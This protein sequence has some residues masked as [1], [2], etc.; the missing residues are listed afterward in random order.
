MSLE[1]S[2]DRR[3]TRSAS[4]ARRAAETLNA[5]IERMDAL[6]RSQKSMMESLQEDM[7]EM[8]KELMRQ[9]TEAMQKMGASIQESMNQ[10]DK[11][12]VYPKK[13]SSRV[14]VNQT[15][16]K[17]E[18]KLS[19]Q[20]ELLSPGM[21]ESGIPITIFFD[22]GSMIDILSSKVVD[23]Y[24]LPTVPLKRPIEVRG[25]Q[26][27]GK[28]DR[29]REK[30]V[31]LTLRIGDHEEI[32]EF[33]V[34]KLDND[35]LLGLPWMQ[36]HGAKF[37][38]ESKKMYFA[39][40]CKDHMVT[41]NMQTIEIK[42]AGSVELSLTSEEIQDAGETL[43][44]TPLVR[45]SSI[46]A[47]HKWDEVGIGAKQFK[48]ILEDGENEI[49]AAVRVVK[50]T[51][52]EELEWPAVVQEFAEVFEK[53]AIPTLPEHR[54]Y[55]INIEL[56][57]DAKPTWGAIYN[58]STDEL[59]ALKNYI[60]DNVAAGFIRPSKS[61]YGAPVLVVKKKDGT[62]RFCIDYR[63]L[64]KQ[65]VKD[66][67][68]L[69]LISE[70]L[71]RVR[72]CKVFSKID[73][74][75]AYNL[76]RIKKGHEW[77]TAFRT[78]Y[79]H[80][81]YCVMPF[82]LS[83]APAA[84]QRMMNSIFHDM[85]DDFMI[86]YLDD[87]LIYSE[88]EEQHEEHLRKVMERLRDNKLM[89]KGEKCEFFRDKV[90]F[91][92]YVISNKGVR[93]DDGKVQTI[94]EWQAPT[95]VKELQ[96]F[97][98]FANF[99]R[100]FIDNYSKRTKNM[101]SLLKKGKP[102]I[103]AEAQQQEFEDLK[104]AF[105]TAP[106]L[107]SADFTKQFI[108]ETDASNFAI[109]AILS[110]RGEDNTEHPVA[111]YS[112]T[113]AAAEQNYQVH[114]KELLAIIEALKHWR[115]YLIGSP[116]PV[117]I[118]TDHRNLEHFMTSQ[119]L[120]QRQ[121]RW[122]Q[123]LADYNFNL[124]Y[125]PGAQQAKADALS[126]REELK[127][128]VPPNTA[129]EWLR[130][131]LDP[132]RIMIASVSTVEF[133]WL[134][135][136][137]RET[138]TEEYAQN[139]I[140]E[141]QNSGSRK[142][143]IQDGTLKKGE[144]TY[145]PENL[146]LR[147]TQ[148][149]HDALESGHKGVAKTLELLKRDFFWPKMEDYVARFVESCDL[150]QRTNANRHASYGEVQITE[151]PTR[152]WQIIG[153]DHAGPLPDSKGKN[154]V[155]II[156]D[157]LT[158]MVHF[159]ATEN[160]T[161]ATTTAELFRDHVWK[162]HGLPE[163]IISDRGPIFIS[164][165]WKRFFE[166]QGVRTAFATGYHPQTNGQ[167]ER[168]VQ[169]CKSYLRKF[170]NYHQDNWVD[171]LSTGEFAYNNTFHSTINDSPFHA[172]TGYHPRSHYSIPNRSEDPAAEDR[173]RELHKAQEKMSEIIVEGKEKT[174]QRVD[175]GRL[176]GP[177]FQVGEK[178]WLLGTNVVKSRRS[179]PLDH[180]KLGPFEITEKLGPVTYRLNLPVNMRRTHNTFHVSLL[181]KYYENPFPERV[182][183]PPPPI[184]IDGE[185]EFEV[186]EILDSRYRYHK[187]QYFVSWKGYTAEHNQWV[188]PEMLSCDELLPAY[189][190]NYPNNPGPAPTDRGQ[191]Q[192]VQGR[193]RRGR[194]R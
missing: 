137:R 103:W 148:E 77:M 35:L 95:K 67:Y 83:N 130:P 184:E 109:G 115:H 183:P 179:A 131:L 24:S 72:C 120:N 6:E 90:E 144:A 145:L 160:T 4:A 12:E 62:L 143:T 165:F 122:A 168:T 112:R 97:L 174:K 49:V 129:E 50:T 18:K 2:P 41:P 152:P 21:L 101:N 70:L 40:N 142:Y 105:A 177:D 117:Q 187:L 98:G 27:E 37:D 113:L 119:L 189:H 44:E 89:A 80:F 133:T 66:R 176:P 186:D 151:T 116:L 20:I 166:L 9:M 169:E 146:R 43:A 172:H 123:L 134:D 194:G 69:P 64:N 164:T 141:T 155:L 162:H 126:R 139:K 86:V 91:L 150:C 75:G 33:L 74:R 108:L 100:R 104:N 124:T 84:F 51:K 170:C 106:I 157:Y 47:H 26:P 175:K 158:K 31:P 93:M 42:S 171:L 94:K 125:R 15:S 118:L 8:G 128:E 32:R 56:V 25:F 107:A 85:L 65:T 3:N 1:R 173:I 10:R 111:F 30:T 11:T 102:Y 48:K 36:E 153:L 71:D 60:D 185:E 28:P 53:K 188:T 87:I 99:Y 22:G 81:E 59:K 68:P 46:K 136:I 76:M 167:A 178:V 135:E 159:I 181:E 78:R 114:D 147:A 156:T 82:G 161:D 14:R 7:Q 192:T 73:L 19:E 140:R 58:M 127:P 23:E 52:T 5:N 13:S 34:T 38:M 92:G 54:P 193:R 138:A 55:D 154:S 17:K 63:Q 96:R 88:N 16:T 110:Q 29:I 79:G 45:I 163:K 180:R 57:P 132:T 121:I 190:R 191:P 39:E 182:V 61:P 149:C